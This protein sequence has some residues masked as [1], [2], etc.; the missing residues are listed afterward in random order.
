MDDEKADLEV[1]RSHVFILTTQCVGHIATKADSI[2]D[3][4]SRS[5]RGLEC[6]LEADMLAKQTHGLAC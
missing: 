3:L 4:P 1:G 2:S 6:P 5:R